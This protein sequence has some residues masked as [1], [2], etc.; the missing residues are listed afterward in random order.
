MERVWTDCLK[1]LGQGILQGQKFFFD[2]Q[3]SKKKLF[4]FKKL[5]GI[6][7]KKNFLIQYNLLAMRYILYLINFCHYFGFKYTKNKAYKQ[8]LQTQGF[9]N[10]E[11]S[12]ESSA[13]SSFS[14]KWFLKKPL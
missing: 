6:F 5:F 2:F 12:A 14:A 8:I 10:S 11:S 1:I 4:E 13:E 3:N 9:S 7:W